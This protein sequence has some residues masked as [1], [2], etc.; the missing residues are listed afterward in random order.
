MT[1][2]T[3]TTGERGL[4]A[5]GHGVGGG[6]TGPLHHPWPSLCPGSIKRSNCYMVWGGDFVS[7]TQQAR[8]SHVDLVI[9]CLVDLATGLMTF[10]ANGKEVN[11]FFQVS[12]A[13]SGSGA[14]GRSKEG[15]REGRRRIQSQHG[16]VANHV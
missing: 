8:I 10:T 11:T 16:A 13:S 7:N 14:S 6:F 1:G 2:A 9:G 4:W 3:S 12:G 15:E 5:Q